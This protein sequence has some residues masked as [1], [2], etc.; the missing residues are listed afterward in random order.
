MGGGRREGN[1]WIC[2]CITLTNNGFLMIHRGL[3]EYAHLSA[4]SALCE[5]QYI[6]WRGCRIVWLPKNTNQIFVFLNLTSFNQTL[7]PMNVIIWSSK[8]IHCPKLSAIKA[9]MWIVFICK[10]FHWDN[11]EAEKK[12]FKKVN[13][14]QLLQCC[15]YCNGIVCFHI[16]FAERYEWEIWN[17]ISHNQ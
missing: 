17:S 11:K 13:C 4:G 1:N 2:F 10:T 3:R 8:A 16:L 7:P 15:N 6:L 14:M 12:V 5:T 9:L